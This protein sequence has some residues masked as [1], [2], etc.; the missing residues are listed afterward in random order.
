MR[1]RRADV[2][3]RFAPLVAA[4]IWCAV[5]ARWL[6]TANLCGFRWLT[7]RSCPLCGLT[8]ALPALVCGSWKEALAQNALSPLA[9]AI[10]AGAPL[11][12]L[13]PA[14]ERRAWQFTAAAFA[15]FGVLRLL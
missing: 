9:A 5:A 1:P 3:L 11:L 13:V 7:G 8:H 4:A 6:E 10:L 14:F 15:G 2:W 12:S